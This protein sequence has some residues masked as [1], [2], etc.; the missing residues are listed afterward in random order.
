VYLWAAR[1][2]IEDM[3]I[4]TQLADCGHAFVR[5]FAEQA[6]MQ[7]FHAGFMRKL[8]PLKAAQQAAALPF[9]LGV[10]SMF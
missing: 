9:R 8:L 4:M 5:S 1:V 6:I 7:A 10:C 3:S 2:V